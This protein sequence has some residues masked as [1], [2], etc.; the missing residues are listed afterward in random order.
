M[1]GCGETRAIDLLATAMN[2]LHAE[3]PGITFALESGDAP[4][5]IDKLDRGLVDFALLNTFTD[6]RRYE[7]VALH[8]QEHW[9][10]L[11]QA[12]DPLQ[13]RDSLSLE[14]LKGLPLILPR[15]QTTSSKSPYAGPPKLPA[16][17]T[18]NLA[19]NA[20]RMTASGMGYAL[21]LDG[22]VE[23]SPANGLASIPVDLPAPESWVL[24][25]RASNAQSPAC[26][27]FAQRIS[28]QFT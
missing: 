7:H 10:L 20:S 21:V 26:R 4:D 17:V 15:R 18:Y 25:W 22:L 8:Y 13:E 11:A 6:A 1:R 24:L 14:E 23:A 9:V 28:Q 12:G 3:H 5:L 27:A 2:D 16:V 19:Y